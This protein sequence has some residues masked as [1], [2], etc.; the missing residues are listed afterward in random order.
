MA[1]TEE[2]YRLI[3]ENEGEKRAFAEAAQTVEGLAQ[4]LADHDCDA[5]PEEFAAHLAAQAQLAGEVADNALEDVAGGVNVTRAPTSLQIMR[6][7]P[8]MIGGF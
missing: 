2:I 1:A 4:F 6:G 3:I 8:C 7:I 5:T